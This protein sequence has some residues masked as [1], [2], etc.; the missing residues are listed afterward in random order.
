MVKVGQG[1]ALEVQDRAE[2]LDGVSHRPRGRRHPRLQ[3]PFVFPDQ[4]LQ[5]PVLRRDGIERFEVQLAELLNVDRTT[6]LKKEK[7]TTIID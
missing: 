2:R 1:D 7:K 5:Q 3:R 6:V 4:P